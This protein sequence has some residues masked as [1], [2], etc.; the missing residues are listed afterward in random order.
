VPDQG[1]PQEFET[2]AMAAASTLVSAMATD[3]WAGV[4][5]RFAGVVGHERLMDQDRAA[6]VEH[7][8]DAIEHATA[9]QT[10]RWAKKIH[11]D[12]VE[13]PEWAAALRS[14][15]TE[16]TSPPA[17]GAPA[18]ANLL[19]HASG[20]GHIQVAAGRDAIV[21]SRIDRRK[22]LLAPWALVV[23][24]AKAIP[25]HPVAAVFTALVVGAAATASGVLAS[26]APGATG[27]ARPGPGATT[28]VRWGESP[29]L[30]RASDLGS[31]WA[32]E[33]KPG[34]DPEEWGGPYCDDLSGSEFAVDANP[35]AVS[36]DMVRD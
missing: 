4:K 1:V 24:A 19:Q 21:N 11:D 7:Q 13:N 18:A 15:L 16:T 12:L 6:L 28:M 22:Y 32:P 35:I 20:T 27:A 8:P 3:A 25:A 10:V 29:S 14:L 26:R 5:K 36:Y 31:G 30:I 2:L 34:D 9:E 33:G 23:H 17:S